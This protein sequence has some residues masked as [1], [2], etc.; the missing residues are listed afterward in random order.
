MVREH[1]NNRQEALSRIG[2]WAVFSVTYRFATIRDISRVEDLLKVVGLPLDGVAEGITGFVLA[3]NDSDIV[4]VA[5]L[6]LYG[7]CGLLRSVAVKPGM[8]K[9][10]IGGELVG[11]V[12]ENAK[13]SG[14]R[15]LFLL[16][17]TAERFFAK[18][19]FV[20]VQRDEVDAS[21]KSSLEFCRVCP[22]TAAAMMRQ[23]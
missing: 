22:E 6:E 20:R 1:D 14:V 10:G 23:I 5:G 13:I 21:V 18:M 2:R 3:E 12:I 7:E 4:G 16:T 19:G 11:R 17:E 15:R 9:H 8:Q